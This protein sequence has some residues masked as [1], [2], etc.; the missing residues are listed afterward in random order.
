V[1][2]AVKPK[3]SSVRLPYL[4]G[5][6]AVA[7]TYVVCFHAALGF[8]SELVG[9]WKVLRLAFAFG[10]EAVAIFI[11]LSGYCLMLPVARTSDGKLVDGLGPYFVRR[12]YRILPPYYATLGA[13]LLAMQLVRV[14]REP[15][16]TMWDESLP[17]L[18]AGPIVSHLLVIH[19]WVPAW[20]FQING[21]L[22]S[23]ATEWQI[24]FFFPLL[25]LP[26]WRRFGPAPTLLVSAIVG[27]AP[28]L[29]AR[30]ASMIAIPWY[31]ALFALGMLAASSSF[32]KGSTEH[33][34][35]GRVPWGASSVVLWLVCAAFGLS[36]PGVWFRLKPL[37]D[38]LVGAAAATLLVHCTEQAINGRRGFL[39]SVL[40]SRP[41][42]AVGHFSYSL[43]LTHLPLLALCYFGLAGL[44]LSGPALALAMLAVGV[45]ASLL[46]GYL[47]YLAVERHFL[48]PPSALLPSRKSVSTSG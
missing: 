31:L 45:P 27:Y 36:M 46:V 11:V 12:A 28:L 23:V 43:Y 2:G 7:A 30:Q 39:L 42:L 10:H 22:W 41:A 8:K 21:P 35:L 24:Y 34:L 5:L 20:A 33:R 15:S 4:D 14:L 17:G 13:S 40:E 6:R 18:A 32:A 19:N 9:P 16:G 1:D 25:L 44:G 29:F 48:R 38:L 47:F 3:P 37:T 26:I